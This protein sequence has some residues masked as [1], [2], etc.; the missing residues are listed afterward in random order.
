MRVKRKVRL[1]KW[2]VLPNL[3]VDGRWSVECEERDG[4]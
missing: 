4:Q 3:Q 2:R 1:V